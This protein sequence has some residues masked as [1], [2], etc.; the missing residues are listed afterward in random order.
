MASED[1]KRRANDEDLSAAAHHCAESTQRVG[2]LSVKGPTYYTARSPA[3]YPSYCLGSA[4]EGSELIAGLPRSLGRRFRLQHIPVQ[5]MAQ[6]TVELPG[7]FAVD[8]LAVAKKLDSALKLSGS[9]RRLFETTY[10]VQ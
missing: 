2:L 1:Q 10:E 8:S 3:E 5:P 4:A 6:P 7:G 9:D